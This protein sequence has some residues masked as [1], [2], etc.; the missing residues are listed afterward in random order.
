M[1]KYFIIFLLIATCNINAQNNFNVRQLQEGYNAK[2][3]KIFIDNFPNNFK[4]FKLIFGW[5]DKLDK[6][7]ALYNEAND[8]IKYFFEL[9]SNNDN[10]KKMIMKIACQAKWEADAV[11]YFHMNLVLLVE[12]DENFDKMLQ[13]LEDKD[14][15]EFWRFYFDIENLIYSQKL[16]TILNAF[17]KE[18]AMYAFNILKKERS[19]YTDKHGKLY[20]YQIFDKDGYCNLRKNGNS[21]SDVI[22]KIENNEIVNVLDS[23][24]DWW[25]IQTNKGLVG[26]VHKSRIKVKN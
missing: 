2:N 23:S 17:M 13:T 5:N 4:D 24:E 8:F 21:K 18:K 14:L 20:K 16:Y 1:N 15:N 10:C 11:N 3:K 12:N 19:N 9:S 7:N 25:F 22:E 6:P 26:F